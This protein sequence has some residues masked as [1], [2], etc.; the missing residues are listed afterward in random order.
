MSELLGRAY[1]IREA[2]DALIEALEDAKPNPC[3]HP[4]DK[5][6]VTGDTMGGGAFVCGE[7][8]ETFGDVQSIRDEVTLTR[9]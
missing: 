2:L 6:K 8:G 5:R 7:C 3:K 9:G 4:W 1:A